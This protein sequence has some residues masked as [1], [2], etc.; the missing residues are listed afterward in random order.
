MFVLILICVFSWFVGNSQS[1]PDIQ[2]DVNHMIGHAGDIAVKA[3]DELRETPAPEVKTAAAPDF[4]FDM[5]H[6]NEH[7]QNVADNILGRVRVSETTEDHKIEADGCNKSLLDKLDSM[8]HDVHEVIIRDNSG[9]K[10]KDIKREVACCSLQDLENCKVRAYDRTNCNGRQASL[11]EDLTIAKH[12]LDL[13]SNITCNDFRGNCENYL[14]SQGRTEV[15]MVVIT[16]LV[17]LAVL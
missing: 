17:A 16:L 12:H 6:V 7:I 1:A 15:S 9:I 4:Q 3:L 8:C 10:D 14:S 13:T 11:Q 2:F 5:K